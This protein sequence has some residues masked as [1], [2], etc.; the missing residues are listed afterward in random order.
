MR[1]LLLFLVALLLTSAVSA[2]EDTTL[3]PTPDPADS[4]LTETF[5]TA[6]GRVSVAYP[7][8]WLIAENFGQ[9]TFL[10]NEDTGLLTEGAVP[11]GVVGGSI[12]IGEGSELPI[13]AGSATLERV[14]ALFAAD[15]SGSSETDADRRVV[16]GDP[17]PLT[18]GDYPA[19]LV[20]GTSANGDQVL[21]T[22]DLGG[23]YY[24]VMLGAT[25]PGELGDSLDLL[26]TMATSVVLNQAETLSF[27]PTLDL[28]VSYNSVSSLGSISIALPEGWSA[29]DSSGSL[30][31]L[32][33]PDPDDLTSGIDLDDPEALLNLVY[34]TVILLPAE[35][36]LAQGGLT[37]EGIADFFVQSLTADNPNLRFDL[38]ERVV[39][40]S[41]LDDVPVVIV[42]PGREPEVDLSL[43]VRDLGSGTYGIMIVATMPNDFPQQRDTLLSIAAGLRFLAVEP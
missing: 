28:P 30:T 32:N 15:I 23:D 9:I 33:S 18:L 29:E 38:P 43:L 34:G 37:L 35:V 36:A 24:A 26:L 5:T 16:F 3:T 19:L 1:P 40:D 14:S 7:V 10:N 11:A 6:N 31:F 8:G 17:E 41:P 13:A 22:L 39:I 25:G 21:I 2:Q 4:L 12:L 42:V 27:T 20:R